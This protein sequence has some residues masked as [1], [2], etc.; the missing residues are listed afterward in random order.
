MTAFQ[1]SQVKIEER[2]ERVA[3]IFRVR[4]Q[5]EAHTLYEAMNADLRAGA[6]HVSLETEPKS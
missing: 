5:D 3:L 2:P 1:A 6:L 4:S